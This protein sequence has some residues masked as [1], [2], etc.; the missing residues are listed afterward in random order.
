M[1]VTPEA[2]DKIADRYLLQESIGR[3]GMGVVWLAWDERLERRVAVKCARLDDDRAARRLMG[4]ARNAGRLHHPNIVGVFDFVDEGA[5]CWIIMEYVPARSL[6]QIL[7]ESGPL[8]PEAAGSIGCQIAA[9][10]AKSHHEGVVHGDVTP[11][12]I[13]VTD[14]GVARLTDFGISRALWS[15]VTHSGTGSV[16]GKPRYLAPELA[17][18][19]PAGEKSDVFSL[20]A[21]LFMAVEGRSPYGEVEHPA[22]YLARA[23]EGHIE[24]AHRAGPLEGPL[25]ALLEVEPRRRPDAARA[26]RLLTHAAP[27]PPHIAEQL[28]DSRRRDLTSPTLVLR[29]VMRR[30]QGSTPLVSQRLQPLRRRRLAITAVALAAAGTTTAGLLL[31]GPWAASKDEGDQGSRTGASDAKPS[32]TA[33]A[34]AIGDERTADP[35]GLL[36]AASLSR[37]GGT[38]LDPYYGEFDRC[39]V[40]VRNS[41]GDDNADVQVNLDSD[42]DDFDDIQSTHLTAGLTI[43]TL[44]RDGRVCERAVLTADGKQVRV[45]GKQLGEVAPDPCQMADAATDHVV[46]VLAYGPVPRRSSLPASNSLAR[47]DTCTLLDATALKRLPGV[48]ADNRDRGFGSWSCDWSS[49]DGKREVE[50]QFSQDNSLDSDDGTAVDVAGTRSYYVADEAEDDS[51]TVRTPHRTYTDSVGGRT[52]ELVQLTVYAPQP[53]RQLCD[54]A[55]EFAADVVRNIAKR[56]AET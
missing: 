21:S 14:E 22:A 35:C 53:D 13:L 23:V 19:L 45:I 54:N 47:L 32:A 15:D 40:L 28:H 24:P 3:G 18:G 49:D 48:D 38:V 46:G 37:F 50:I 10:L 36:D 9:A 34:G 2:G 52:T 4:E 17:K 56:L 51:C 5:T 1:L 44:K 16:G 8:T 6:A 33:P 26:Q 55:T 25:T 30:A 27:P 42:R 20:G 41:S 29:R 11:E 31:F 39:D 7:T 12:N 43:V